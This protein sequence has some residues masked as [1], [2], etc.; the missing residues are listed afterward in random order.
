MYYS[1]QEI[2]EIARGG[3]LKKAPQT[4]ST[5]KTVL[6]KDVNR[7]AKATPKRCFLDDRKHAL[8][9]SH[10]QADSVN[11]WA[12]K[13]PKGRGVERML[14]VKDVRTIRH[15]PRSSLFLCG[16]MERTE[17]QGNPAYSERQK[18]AVFFPPR[19]PHRQPRGYS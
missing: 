3:Y 17:R 12:N 1:G 16:L 15:S 11:F 7:A 13:R 5:N 4:R 2:I 18:L 6:S 9:L 10:L 8:K 14:K 19:E